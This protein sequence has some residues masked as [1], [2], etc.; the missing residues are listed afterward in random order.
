MTYIS[1]Q[2]YLRF[3]DQSKKKDEETPTV[4]PA[5]DA[6]D[7]EEDKQTRPKEEEK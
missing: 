5:G 2:D 3:C 4:P 6:P 1:I 7:S